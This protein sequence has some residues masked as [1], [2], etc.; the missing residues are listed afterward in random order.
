MTFFQ[1]FKAYFA[2]YNNHVILKLELSS[3]LHLPDLMQFRR[4]VT[5]RHGLDELKKFAVYGDYEKKIS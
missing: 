1:N 5:I 2:W 3:S 4:S